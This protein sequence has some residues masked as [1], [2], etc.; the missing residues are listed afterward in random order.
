LIAHNLNDAE[1][2]IATVAIHG[3]ELTLDIRSLAGTYK[4]THGAS[5]EIAGEWSSGPT[6]IPLTFKPAKP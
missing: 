1:I 5:G 4:G 3:K 2:P 6:H